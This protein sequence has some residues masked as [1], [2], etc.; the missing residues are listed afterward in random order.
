MYTYTY[1]WIY[2]KITK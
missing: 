2:T 1:L